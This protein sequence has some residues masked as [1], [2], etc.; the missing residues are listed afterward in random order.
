MAANAE[1]PDV[2]TFNTSD[3]KRLEKRFKIW[4]DALDEVIGSGGSDG[5]RLFDRSTKEELF[6]T[7][8]E[9]AICGQ[10]I[11]DIDDAQVDHVISWAE[12]GKTELDNAQLA[13]RYCNQAK[14]AS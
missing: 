1:F 11:R 10:L 4:K 9:C 8:A 2:I 5:R 12:G 6:S 7:S 14:G 13:H 3:R